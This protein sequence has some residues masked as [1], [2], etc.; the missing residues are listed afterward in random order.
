M[1]KQTH[2]CQTIGPACWPCQAIPSKSTRVTREGQLRCRPK[3]L[4]RFVNTMLMTEIFTN[5][6]SVLTGRLVGINML[7]IAPKATDLAACQ[8]IAQAQIA[9]AILC[10]RE[11]GEK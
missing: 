3:N 11:L 2:R 1:R 9:A 5:R 4:G 10:R 7:E 6:H 8:N